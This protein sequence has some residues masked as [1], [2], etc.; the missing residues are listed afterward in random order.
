MRSPLFLLPIAMAAGCAVDFKS[1]NGTVYPSGSGAENAALIESARADLPC[2][3][4][5]IAV[6]HIARYHAETWH[7]ADGCGTRGIY[8]LDCAPSRRRHESEAPHVCEFILISRV[9]LSP[10]PPS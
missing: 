9:R 7:L 10:E 3:T 8:L 6:R 2:A 1:S 5:K 4:D